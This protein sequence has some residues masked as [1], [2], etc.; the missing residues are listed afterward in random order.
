MEFSFL[1]KSKYPGCS[2]VRADG[3][4]WPGVT[5]KKKKGSK[6]KRKTCLVKAIGIA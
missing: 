1:E 2:G 5:I 3:V 6:M 4:G